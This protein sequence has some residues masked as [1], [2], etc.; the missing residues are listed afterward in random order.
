MTNNKPF[1]DKAITYMTLIGSVLGVVY[2]YGQD[3]GIPTEYLGYVEKTLSFLGL[4]T[5]ATFIKK[6]QKT[7]KEIHGL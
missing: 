2:G 5:G 7:L 4:L 6:D 3:M 1:G